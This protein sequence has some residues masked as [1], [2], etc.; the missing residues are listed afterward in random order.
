M[1]AKTPIMPRDRDPESGKF[2][3]AYADKRFIEALRATDGMAGSK[4]VAGQVGCSYET[5]YR[6]LQ[7]LA[8]R[9]RVTRRTVGNTIMWVLADE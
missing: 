4:E 8:D 1:G 3:E 9:G 2:R 6:K 7:R 5:A